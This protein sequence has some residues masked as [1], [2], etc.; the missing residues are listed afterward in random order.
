MALVVTAQKLALGLAFTHQKKQMAVG[1]LN[2]EDGDFD[3]DAGL[4][5]NLE[6]LALAVSLHVQSDDARGAVAPGRTI[7]DL[8]P[9]AHASKLDVEQVRVHKP[10]DTIRAGR[11]HSKPVDRMD[12]AGF[13]RDFRAFLASG[14]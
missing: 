6:E 9:S 8:Q 13:F 4:A 11:V 14:T 10:Q 7:S 3:I 2:V 5:N 1:G 12:D